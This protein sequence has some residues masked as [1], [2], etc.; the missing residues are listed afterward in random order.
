M[1]SGKEELVRVKEFPKII[2]GLRII[3]VLRVASS[4]IPWVTQ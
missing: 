2:E 1:R 3:H 4:L